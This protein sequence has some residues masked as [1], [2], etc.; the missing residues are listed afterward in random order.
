MI[1]IPL[2]KTSQSVTPL[3]HFS[4]QRCAKI[5]LQLREN[6]GSWKHENTKK[7]HNFFGFIL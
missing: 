3:M 6:I 7:D 4:Q 1:D 5:C 2:V